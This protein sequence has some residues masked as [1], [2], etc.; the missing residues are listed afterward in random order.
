MKNRYAILLPLLL[1]VA[2]VA[3]AQSTE[4]L[5]GLVLPQMTTVQRTAMVSPAEGSLVFDTTTKTYWFRKN[6]N[7]VELVG[8][9]GNSYWQLA[10]AAG[11]EIQNTNVGG[12]WSKNPTQVTYNSPVTPV[13]INEEGTR[14]MWLPG[15]SAFRVGTVSNTANW[16]ADSIGVFSFAAGYN[17][18]AKGAYSAAMGY[19]SQ[20]N[21]DNSIALGRDARAYGEY[22]ISLGGATRAEGLGSV[23]LGSSTVAKK[24]SSIAGGFNTISSGDYAVALGV[25]VQAKG[26]GSVALG[27][28]TVAS[29]PNS[30]AAGVSTEATSDGSVAIGNG[31]RAEAIASVALGAS[32]TTKG[33]AAFAAGFFT[34][35]SGDYSTALGANTKALGPTT[36]AFGN[37]TLA[38][39]DIALATGHKTVASGEKS[40]AMGSLMNTNN[41]KG[42]FMIGDSDPDNEGVT[43]GGATDQLVARF[44]NGYYLLTSGNAAPRTG[45][46]I[47]N[48]QTAWSA[49]SD[50]T[51]KERFLKANGELFLGKLRNLRLGSWNYKGRGAKPERFYGPMAQELFAAYGK[52]NYGTIGTDTTVSTINMDGLLFIFSQALEK[53]TADLQAE[54]SQL[55]RMIQQHESDLSTGKQEVADIRNENQQLRNIIEK[56]DARL[57]KMETKD[58]ENGNVIINKAKK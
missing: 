20:A 41:L 28:N 21:A 2:N 43:F 32:A 57:S 54:N 27:N 34:R 50:S 38:S 26:Q 8:G 48:G 37:E 39:G 36:T 33:A 11:N 40:T 53:R 55:K 44:K 6:N 17:P 19:Y 12:F 29:G 3:L 18:Q 5:P 58:E 15:R 16:S 24:N 42:V 10:G 9:G 7:W 56:L 51:R 46:M 52:D 14:L 31:A 47:G 23:A 22:S 30:F 4:I 49:I 35:A 25:S 1:L 45:V 13:P